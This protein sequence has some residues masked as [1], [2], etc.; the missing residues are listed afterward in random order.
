MK[1][2]LV[3]P[4][5]RAQRASV[6]IGSLGDAE[7]ATR[8]RRPIPTLAVPAGRLLR[9]DSE[10]I[11]ALAY[12]ARSYGTSVDTAG[13][14]PRSTRSHWCAEARRITTTATRKKPATAASM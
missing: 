2:P 1:E 13:T 9:D 8:P 7:P 4:Q 3:I 14:R 5:E 11:A 10:G 12:A 6:G